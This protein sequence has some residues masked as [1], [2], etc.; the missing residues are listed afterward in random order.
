MTP[1]SPV[2]PVTA[3]II[4]RGPRVVLRTWTAADVELISR[5][6]CDP[7]TMRFAG[8]VDRSKVARSLATGLRAFAERGVCLWA[9]EV[10]GELVGDCGFHA[11]DDGRLELGYH[12][13]ADRWGRGL[14]TEAARAVID[15]ARRALPGRAIV[16]WVHPDNPTS[17][18]VLR[19]CGFVEIGPDPAE[20]GEVRFALE[21]S[22]I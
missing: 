12:L 17:G 1:D 2:L 5:V 14:A 13:R 19:K 21:P 15:Y 22:A 18:A 11:L 7:D 4:A 20:D 16:A 8:V 6:W 10:D 9:V 3:A